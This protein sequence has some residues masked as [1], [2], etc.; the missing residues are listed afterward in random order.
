MSFL[1]N[2]DVFELTLYNVHIQ[3]KK[4]VPRWSNRATWKHRWRTRGE[5]ESGKKR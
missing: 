5:V 3:P 2:V 4:G 1:L